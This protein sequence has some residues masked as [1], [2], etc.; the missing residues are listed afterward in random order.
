L[1]PARFAALANLMVGYRL[2]AVFHALA[3]PTRRSMLARLAEGEVGRRADLRLRDERCRRR[4]APRR[5]RIRRARPRAACGPP[6]DTDPL[7]EAVLW[8]RRWQLPESPRIARLRAMLDA[9]ERA[10]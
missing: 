7:G 1:D 8:L 3:D 6:L 2:D 4:Q 10:A 5:A 9:A